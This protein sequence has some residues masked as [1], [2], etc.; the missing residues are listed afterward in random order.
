MD[1]TLLLLVILLVFIAVGMYLLFLI[2]KEIKK[3]IDS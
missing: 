1:L 2:L 3:T